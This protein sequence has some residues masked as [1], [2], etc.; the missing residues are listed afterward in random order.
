M[1]TINFFEKNEKNEK[2][3]ELPDFVVVR[4]QKNKNKLSRPYSVWPA[5]GIRDV[6]QGGIC[7]SRSLDF[8]L[9]V[10]VVG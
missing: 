1:T 7:F 9:F 5:S 2:C 8:C 10:L 4:I 6:C 3:L